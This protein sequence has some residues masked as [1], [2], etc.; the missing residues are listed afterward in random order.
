MIV[1]PRSALD[2]LAGEAFIRYAVLLVVFGLLLTLLNAL[3]FSMLGFDWLGTR[4]ELPNPTY[5]GFFGRLRVDTDHYVTIF[6]LLLN[7]LMALISLIFIPGLAQVASKIWKGTGTFAQTGE[8]CPL[9]QA[10]WWG[11]MIGVYI[12]A[13]DAWSVALG[14]LAIH[15]IQKIPAWAAG[16]IMLFGYALWYYGIA[17]TFVR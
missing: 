11:Y 6:N 12:L 17:G 10:L 5:I 14:A 8:F 9:V 1:R 16:I 4:R 3:L 2:E 7:P 15:R 13:K